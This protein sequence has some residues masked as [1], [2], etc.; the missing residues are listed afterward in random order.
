MNEIL[1][2]INELEA[3]TDD[4]MTFSD[5]PMQK[6]FE[7]LTEK[8]QLQVI[9]DLIKQ[10]ILYQKYP[11]PNNEEEFL[12][13]D[14][15][16]SCKAFI[17]YLKY[18][19]MSFSCKIAIGTNKNNLDINEYNGLNFF[20]IAKNLNNNN[21][22]Y[23][24]PSLNIG[25]GFG[26]TEEHSIYDNF[27]I[28][29]DEIASFLQSIRL[30]MYHIHNKKYNNI[31]IELFN[32]YKKY[33]NDNNFNGLLLKYS[34]CINNS[35]FEKL[36]EVFNDE[37]ANKVEYLK[38]IKI[39]NKIALKK[40]TLLNYKKLF[41]LLKN[42]I[43]NPKL[44]QQLAQNIVGNE[45]KNF[46]FNIFG[47]ERE[48]NYFNPRFFWENDC[49][50]VLLKPSTYLVNFEEEILNY[51][52]PDK[53]N[54]V[55]SYDINLGNSTSL[56][57]NP[58]EY[59]HPHGMKYLKAME[60]PSK[61]FL[62]KEFAEDL[63]KRKHFVRKHFAIENNGK[64]VDWFD[65]SKILWDTNLNTNLVHSTD[66]ALETSIHFLAGYPEYQSFTRFNYPN[67]KFKRRK[68]R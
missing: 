7:L 16:T 4:R 3:I 33:F 48:I 5:S 38:Q 41:N 6:E 47:E 60:G 26:K 67:P 17:K 42:N 21:Y 30:T 10:S 54:I 23:I 13:G 40:N 25:D 39:K 18:L 58:M 52:I 55:T 49:N 32:K 31:E 12:I 62:V 66:D 37:F 56:G 63:K 36:K 1:P 44:E 50:V 57:L 22:Y 29:N 59:F 45:E 64:Y 20:V 8:N 35:D 61:I 27:L 28:I 68:K 34:E 65:G 11:N 53:N 2:K 19:K 15:Y 51:M 24:N 43:N 46:A 14:D 9:T